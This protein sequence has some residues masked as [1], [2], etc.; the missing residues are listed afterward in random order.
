[1]IAGVLNEA[2]HGDGVRRVGIHAGGVF[3]V[4]K[5]FRGLADSHQGSGVVDQQRGVI[6]LEAERGFVI[7]PGLR[8]VAVI[9]LVLP[10]KEVGGGCELGIGGSG[11]GDQSIGIDLAVADD[12]LG[13]VGFVVERRRGRSDVGGTGLDGCSR[14]CSGAGVDGGDTTGIDVVD[15]RFRDGVSVLAQVVFHVV[16]TFADLVG[17]DSAS[18]LEMD[19]VG[20]RGKRRKKH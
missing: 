19:D 12:F 16:C 3:G 15:G 9:G 2:Q 17:P 10:G 14:G 7:A 6:R 1:M 8:E 20:G 5:G 4:G 11:Q 18:I 13:Y